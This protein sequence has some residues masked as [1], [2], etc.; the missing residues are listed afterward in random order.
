M[1]RVPSDP[2]DNSARLWLAQRTNA[3]NSVHL[4][5]FDVEQRVADD[6]AFIAAAEEGVKSI[7]A[8]ALEQHLGAAGLTIRLAA[9]E[10]IPKDV[11]SIFRRLF[12]LMSQ[13]A[14]DRKFSREVCAENM[15]DQVIIL[16]QNRIHG[17]L[18]SAFWQPPEHRKED[19]SPLYSDLREVSLRIKKVP[20]RNA[21]KSRTLLQKL[22]DLCELFQHLDAEPRASSNLP[23][24]L[25]NIIKQCYAVSTSDG[26]CTFNETVASYGY[27]PKA[28][29]TN[30]YIEQVYKLGRYWGLCVYLAEA[31][32]KYGNVF[33]SINL[34]TVRPY[35]PI[36]SPI[37]F[38]RR[39][40]E[41]HVHAEIQLLIFYDSNPDVSILKPRVL[42]VSKAACYLCNHFTKKHAEFFLSQTHGHLYDQWNVPD[43][44]DFDN[45]Q[46]LKYR[47]ILKSM[48]TELQITIKRERARPRS[49]KRREPQGSRINL[50]TAFHPSSPLASDAGTV[51]SEVDKAPQQSSLSRITPP[52]EDPS[53]ALASHTISPQN[54]SQAGA[55]LQS[56][57]HHYNLR[58]NSQMPPASFPPQ[59]HH[60]QAINERRTTFSDI[61]EAPHH[62]DGSPE[63]ITT[64]SMLDEPVSSLDQPQAPITPST[65]LPKPSSPSR[66]PRLGTHHAVYHSP[67]PTISSWELPTSQHLTPTNPLHLLVGNLSLTIEIE[68]PARGTVAIT[69]MNIDGISN[70]DEGAIVDVAEMEQGE[71]RILECPGKGGELN[72]GLRYGGAGVELLLGWT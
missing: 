58:S 42:G 41:C 50:L 1:A 24:I 70:R 43:L 39:R 37:S 23:A 11:P 71:E 40:V 8:I 57:I 27:E 13:C 28:V 52:A 18:Q 46:R 10:I 14:T 65:I 47:S 29:L 55:P 3:V 12:D 4:L 22:N 59:H 68:E 67:V 5:P 38:K 2:E 9:N 53:I 25:K 26:T 15:F 51:Q 7:S 60:T 34:A 56:Y 69:R 21:K 49:Q 16:S 33:Q 30:K 6:L 36:I 44:A 45:A 32:R 62:R 64:R 20:S 72:L 17:R 66:L 54:Q 35:R 19:R 63:L 61:P 48:D 31:S